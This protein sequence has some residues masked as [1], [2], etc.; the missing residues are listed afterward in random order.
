MSLS[1]DI[2]LRSLTN[3]K[4]YKCNFFGYSFYKNLQD[5]FVCVSG[6]GVFLFVIAWSDIEV[7]EKEISQMLIW[8]L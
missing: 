5:F 6:G 8:A 3:T 2:E 1:N 4:L 7:E